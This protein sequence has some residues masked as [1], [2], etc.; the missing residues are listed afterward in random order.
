[1]QY[2]PTVWS[3][4]TGDP[5][6]PR[7]R[8]TQYDPGVWSRYAAPAG[9]ALAEP[10]P[11]PQPRRTTLARA[12]GNI[13][14]MFRTP[15]RAEAT[16][17][18]PFGVRTVQRNLVELARRYPVP[19]MIGVGRGFETTPIEEVPPEERNILQDFVAGFEAERRAG[20]RA[21]GTTL[22]SLGL[23]RVGRALREGREPLPNLRPR[24]RTGNRFVDVLRET[25]FDVGGG[26]AST[27]PSIVGGVVGTAVGGP[28]GGAVGALAPAAARTYGGLR[29]EL[30]EEGVAP[31]TASRAAAVVTPLSSALEVLVP[32]SI[33][34]RLLGGAG[35]QAARGVAREIARG[36]L[37][38]GVTEAAT[39]AA[40]TA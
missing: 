1:Q 32:L 8:R 31:Q 36:A 29:E 14:E 4:Y 24:E 7:R 26:V 16:E 13:R 2:D 11:E 18:E 6:R 12:L 38:E 30:E 5:E 22:E 19:G 21:Y 39:E 33:G 9:P 28:V 15:E 10:D 3:R 37:R 20:R 23:E 27:L 35:Q 17:R 25:A 34:R 40:Q